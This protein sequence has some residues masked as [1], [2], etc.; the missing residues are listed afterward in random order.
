MK[1]PS[2]NQQPGFPNN[3]MQPNNN[4]FQPPMQEGNQIAFKNPNE[5]MQAQPK[6]MF[7]PMIASLEHGVFIKQKFELMEALSACET[8]N[9]YI[10]YEMDQ[11]GKKKG[12]ELLKFKEKSSFC[13]RQYLKGNQRPVMINTFNLHN[14]HNLCMI[15]EKPYKITVACLNRPV[16][17]IQAIDQ[18]GQLR[19]VGKVVDNFDL[20]NFSFSVLDHTG[21]KRFHIAAK[22]TQ[23]GLLCN[24]P[25]ESC[26]KVIFQVWRGDKESE[27]S[28]LVKTG[29]GCSKNA[30]GDAN[31]F[32]IPFPP[33]SD[34]LDRCLLIATAM[35]IDYCMFE[36]KGNKKNSY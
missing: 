1:G 33:Q 23:L 6:F 7:A 13:A 12:M 31:C 3:G 29:R 2:Q 4:G 21:K 14:N 36:D 35:F 18:N 10:L 17:R 15:L 22:C 20:C 25:C 9:K 11:Q 26:Q 5:M 8:Q 27:C 16:L 30:F 28:P 19:E 34:H 24:F 32:S